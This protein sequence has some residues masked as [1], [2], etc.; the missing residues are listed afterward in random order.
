MLEPWQRMKYVMTTTEMSNWLFLRNHA[1]A[2]PEIKV[3]AALMQDVLNYSEVIVHEETLI[4]KEGEAHVP[5]IARIR[6]ANE[7]LRYFVDN[8]NEIVEVDLETA[9]MISSSCCAQVSYR[10]NDNSIDKAL[11]VY[12]R[13]V[14]SK[15]A[16]YSPFEHQAF[17]VRKGNIP[18]LSPSWEPGITHMMKDG[19]LCSGNLVGWV[20]NRQ[21]IMHK[22]KEDCFG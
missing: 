19:S 4:L 1:D 14:E 10:L 21:L 18:N 2:Q 8:E 3:V 12:K 17:P 11:K 16:H 9:I 20:Q 5:Y 15:P 6:D 22:L 13:L 7:T